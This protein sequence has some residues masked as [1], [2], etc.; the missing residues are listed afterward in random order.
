M[1]ILA[2]DPGT[3][4]SGFVE[5][6]PEHSKTTEDEFGNVVGAVNFPNFLHFAVMENQ[7][8]L[9]LLRAKERTSVLVIE[10]FA[11]YGMAVGREVLEACEFVGECKEAF[12]AGPVV[13]VYRKDIKMH[14]CGQPK[15]KDG[16]IAQA[17][18]DK[19]GDKGTK[20]APGFFYGFSSHTWQAFAL[21]A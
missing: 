19:Y 9:R 15:A 1:T 18:R 13:L 14:H 4:E 21:A 8:L 5:W 17:L 11:C 10:R 12:K 6:T 3:T 20:Q 16:N 7:T 2:I